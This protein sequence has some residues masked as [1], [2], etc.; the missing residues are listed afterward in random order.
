MT[1]IANC[2]IDHLF[3]DESSQAE[4]ALIWG[5]PIKLVYTLDCSSSSSFID[6]QKKQYNLRPSNFRIMIKRN[7]FY[8]NHFQSGTIDCGQGFLRINSNRVIAQQGSNIENVQKKS[9]GIIC[10]LQCL[11]TTVKITMRVQK[12]NPH[13]QLVGGSGTNL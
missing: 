5:K 13:F 9:E 8:H 7:Y 1:S 6:S 11:R 4:K 2:S 12:V 10:F 3:C